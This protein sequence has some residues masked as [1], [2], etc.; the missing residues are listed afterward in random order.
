MWE[1]WISICGMDR[2]VNL[3]KLFTRLIDEG[4]SEGALEAYKSK[5]ELFKDDLE[6]GVCTK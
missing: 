5:V 1:D 2:A 6:K 4:D 3:L